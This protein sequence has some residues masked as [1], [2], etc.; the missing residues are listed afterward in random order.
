MVSVTICGGARIYRDGLVLAL[1][2]YEGLS[3]VSSCESAARL[4]SLPGAQWP[5]VVLLDIQS[6]ASPCSV[7]GKLRAIQPGVRCSIVTLGI[8]PEEDDTVVGLLAAGAAGYTTIN[9][10]IERLASV[11]FGA[12]RGELLGAP[13]LTRLMQERLLESPSVGAA[14]AVAPQCLSRRE[15]QVIGLVSQGHSNKQIARQLCLELPTVKNHMHS[16][17]SKLG[18]RNRYEAARAV[19]VLAP[20]QPAS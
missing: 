19:G 7:V 5:D 15:Q 4:L 11:L 16:V 18:V 3:H 8:N 6:C 9:D 20:I 1:R 14:I 17:I 13:R 12:A 2:A 10:S